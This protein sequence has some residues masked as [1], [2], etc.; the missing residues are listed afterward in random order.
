MGPASKA[1]GFSE[2][3]SLSQLSSHGNAISFDSWIGRR[4]VEVGVGPINGTKFNM[5]P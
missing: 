4:Q 1:N 3:H 5:K 2:T